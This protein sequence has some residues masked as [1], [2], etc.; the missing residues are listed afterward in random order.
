MAVVLCAA[1]SAAD[2]AAPGRFFV[3]APAVPRDA[4]AP[5]AFRLLPTAAAEEEQPG[6]DPHPRYQFGYE[7]ADSL[8]GD[9][10]AREETRDG[11]LVTGSYTVADPD[12]RIR[13]VIYSADPVNGFQARVTYDGAAGPVAIPV[14]STPPGKATVIIASPAAVAAL[15]A[16]DSDVPAAITVARTPLAALNTP[17]SIVQPVSTIFRQAPPPSL[18]HVFRQP[19]I[20]APGP[21]LDFSQ[22]RFLPAAESP[23]AFAGPPAPVIP[24]LGLHHTFGPAAAASGLDLSQFRFVSAGNV[25]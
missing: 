10:K 18:R 13:T 12:G 11:D 1:G 23:A 21:L 17:S 15:P 7:V 25:V 16:E 2:Y 22:F 9:S 3:A 4:A 14:E 6:Y 24:P 19:L 20:P 5:G 8:S